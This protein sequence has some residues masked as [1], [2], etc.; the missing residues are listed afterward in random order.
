M[1]SQWKSKTMWLNGAI[2]WAL[3]ISGVATVYV[4]DL[5]LDPQ[6][7]VRIMFG[8]GLLTTLGNMYLRK[9]HTSEALE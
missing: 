9:Y 2:A 4:P 6:V 5:G 3:A 8:L 7:T 1:K